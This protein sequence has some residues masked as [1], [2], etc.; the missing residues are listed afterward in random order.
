MYVPACLRAAKTKRDGCTNRENLLSSSVTTLDHGSWLYNQQVLG[1]ICV[2]NVCTPLIGD[3]DGGEVI[4]NEYI[5]VFK[6]RSGLLTQKAHVHG[7]AVNVPEVERRNASV[8][9][10]LMYEYDASL[11]VE[12]YAVRC[13]DVLLNTIRHSK[14][15]AYVEKN[16]P[17]FLQ[18]QQH[19]RQQ[20][21]RQAQRPAA[22][23]RNSYSRPKPPC[24]QQSNAAWA[25][26]R[27][28]AN[29]LDAAL[30]TRSYR[31]EETGGTGVD[32]YV[33]DTGIRLDHVDLQGRARWGT[34][35]IDGVDSPRTDELGHGTHVAG[36]VGGKTFG[37]AK[38][39]NVVAVKV[40]DEGGRTSEAAVVDGL[41][42]IAQDFRRTRK[43]SIINLSIGGAGH[44][45]TLNRAVKAIIKLGISCVVAAGNSEMD[46]CYYSPAMVSESVTVANTNENDERMDSSNFG[47]CVDIFAPGTNIR[48]LGVSSR[49]ATH[50]DSG[51]S[52]SAPHVTGVL[53]RWLSLFPQAT[54]AQLKRAII[55][56]ST[57][58]TIG[59][60]NGSP[61]QMLHMGC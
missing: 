18:Q 59:N 57:K 5:V 1:T 25:L 39:V 3:E 55:R 6:D 44:Y 19:G 15:V 7:V 32:V 13:D 23:P 14:E 9:A 58:H 38:K 17:L 42:W 22:R 2:W 52:M 36:I 33:V 43:P 12:G 41:R 51:T 48:S 20:R 45:W 8:H 46:A 56:T 28:S 61:N 35:T 21:P 54:P 50:V 16:R 31:Y 11:G 49:Y 10:K 60:P 24:M 27:I 26:S 34:D 40:F 37:V 4:E 53:A 47:Q 30:N 29:T